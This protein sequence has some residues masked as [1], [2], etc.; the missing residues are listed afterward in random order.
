MKSCMPELG[1]VRDIISY[2]P[3]LGDDRD[4]AVAYFGG[5]LETEA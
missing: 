5:I 1:H 4:E 3:I 2:H